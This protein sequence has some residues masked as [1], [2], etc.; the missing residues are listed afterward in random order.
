METI[1]MADRSTEIKPRTIIQF[2]VIIPARNESKVIG[3]CLEA[4]TNQ[5]FPKESFEVILVDNGSTDN[6]IEIVRTFQG[7]PSVK[8]IRLDGVYISALRNRGSKEAH[9]SVYVFLDA[10]C[11][12]AP[13]WL[14]SAA[15]IFQNGETGIAGAHYQ[16]PGD[17][18]WVGRSWF[19]DR[20][21]E[22]FGAVKYI[23]SGDLMMSREVFQK[24]GGFDETIQTNEDFELCQRAWA[25][26]TTVTSY[27]ELQVV[28]LGTPRT[29]SGFFKKQRWHGT[30]VFRVFLRDPEKK[31]N[32]KP[33]LLALYTL[34]C[35]VAAVAGIGF[36]LVTSH[37]IAFA[38]A[39]GML[40]LPLFA[41]SLFRCV[42][43]GRWTDVFPL[44]TLYVTYAVARALSILKLSK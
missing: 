5:N 3:L 4:L 44:T 24:L 16:I 39:L 41:I 34:F 32:R 8:V 23:P 42:T 1:D 11:I 37:W 18:T 2:S 43:A 22:K 33:V 21:S 35:L 30:H 31:K 38:V 26:G 9:G 25:N 40:I 7:L 12:P 20:S 6:T 29:L 13:G 28:H 36:G 10:D 14:S 17:A 15:R 19:E 27:R